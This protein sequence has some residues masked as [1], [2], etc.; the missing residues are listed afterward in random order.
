MNRATPW[1]VWSLG[2]SAYVVAVLN[3]SSLGVTG[4]E[5]QQRLGATATV[6]ALFGVVQLGVY[7]AMQIPVGMLLD[8]FGA[9]RMVA[10]GAALMAA[11]QLA[12]AIA[13]DVPTAAAA[14]VLVGLGDA[15]T[16]VSVL[17]LVPAWFPARRAPLLTQVTGLT[18]QLGQVAAAFPLVL[19]LDGIGWTPTFVAVAAVGALVAVLVFVALRDSPPGAP[20]AVPV[21]GWAERR[22]ELAA[23]WR[24]P[25]TRLGLWTHFVTMFPGTVF[26]LLWGY[27]FL[28]AG[29]G[30]GAA[31]ASTLFTVMV[32]ASVV[33]GVVLGQLAG[34]WP[35]RRSAL[36]F[37]VVAVTAA[38][39]APVLL[40]PGPA[41][42]PVLVLLV[43]ALAT[44]G[45]GSMVAFD[46]ARTHNPPGRLGTATGIV[47]VGG[48]VASLA[49]MFA[50]GVVLDLLAPAGLTPGAFRLAFT[51]QYVFWAVGLVGVIV[52]R[53]RVRRVLAAQGVVLDPLP[54][55]VARRLRV[56][57]SWA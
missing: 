13:E 19:A 44:N 17:R 24:E 57:L 7:A 41:P 37:A 46:Y 39:W 1:L 28:L 40:W 32:V 20:A 15:M 25:G 23:A 45:P 16:F 14:R 4:L 33:V 27:P 48:F 31:T 51:V 42:L 38:A 55:A 11:G 50:I 56:A 5:A 47:N 9:R 54:R 6:L 49:A 52:T 53:R 18:G 8:R 21:T 34:R 43:L 35:L 12:L 26:A 29:Q 2:L 36:V 10:L 30:L 3:R 22:A